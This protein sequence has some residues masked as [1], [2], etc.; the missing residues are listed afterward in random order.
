MGALVFSVTELVGSGCHGAIASPLVVPADGGVDE[1][2]SHFLLLALK[3]EVVVGCLDSQEGVVHDF[4][5]LLLELGNNVAGKEGLVEC[6][7]LA[8]AR[9]L[10]GLVVLLVHISTHVDSEDGSVGRFHQLTEFI[11]YGGDG[12]V[13]LI[14]LCD[15]LGH[16]TTPMMLF[17]ESLRVVALMRRNSPDL[18]RTSSSQLEVL[19]PWSVSM[20]IFLNPVDC[21]PENNLQR[22]IEY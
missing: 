15:V 8:I 9:Y 4:L 2:V 6:F 7:L 11:G 13:V 21:A 10:R 16:P 22:Q 5:H 14:G 17:S 12:E 3:V 19:F 20:K 1:Q 18:V